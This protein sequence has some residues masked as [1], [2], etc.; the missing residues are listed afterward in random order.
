MACVP[1]ATDPRDP[2]RAHR[3]RR[4]GAHSLGR[5]GCQASVTMLGIVTR[6]CEEKTSEHSTL[7]ETVQAREDVD[8]VPGR[9]PQVRC[10]QRLIEHSKP[11]VPIHYANGA[12]SDPLRPHA[13]RGR[14]QGTDR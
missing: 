4:R 14:L 9:L 10:M 2:C 5:L 12:T 13:R 8:L 7:L 11:E 1:D 6:E 3:E